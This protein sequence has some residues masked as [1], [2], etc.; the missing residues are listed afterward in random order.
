MTKKTTQKI[1]LST[2]VPL[3][4]YWIKQTQT[5]KRH[6]A[7]IQTNEADKKVILYDFCYLESI[8]WLE[9]A[10]IQKGH[11]LFLEWSFLGTASTRKEKNFLNSAISSENDDVLT[12]HR[13]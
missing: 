1:C 13:Q 7:E 12:S 8:I 3:A 10:T 6:S 5:Y 9:R 2:N 4:A 11:F